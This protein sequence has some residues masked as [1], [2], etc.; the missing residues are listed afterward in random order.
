MMNPE[1]FYT[2]SGIIAKFVLRDIHGKDSGQWL[3]VGGIESTPWRRN[4]Q[5]RLRLRLAQ[6][7]SGTMP[8]DILKDAP[9]DKDRDTAELLSKI[10][11][12]WS[13]TKAFSQKGVEEF[14][15]NTP[16]V[17]DDLDTFISN[18]GHFLR[19]K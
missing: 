15:Y 9:E 6:S 11:A 8:E 3:M 12:D 5:E 1:D 2:R 14:L 10:V 4:R 18:K 13:F 16:Y 17:M 19:K 7:L